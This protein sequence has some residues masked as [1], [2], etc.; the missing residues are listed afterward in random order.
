MEGEYSMDL[1]DY[2]DS[3]VQDSSELSGNENIMA[4]LE[5][6]VLAL[7]EQL[8]DCIQYF[9]DLYYIEY[10]PSVYNRTYEL[11][12]ALEVSNIV[13]ISTDAQSLSIN[14]DFNDSLSWGNSIF[15]GS[16][17]Y[18]PILIDQGWQVE[19]DVWFKNIEHFGFQSGAHFIENGIER[20]K[21][22]INNPDVHVFLDGE[23]V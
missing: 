14:L 23:E 7:A 21:N 3:L 4:S 10:Y 8:K 6:Y 19:K 18:K 2:I 12:Q 15:N 22:E 11:Q 1:G 13:N 9:L 5:E 20:F 16:D 17:G